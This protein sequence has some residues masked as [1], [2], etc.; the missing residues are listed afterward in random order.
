MT[1]EEIK[2]AIEHF[3]ELTKNSVKKCQKKNYQKKVKFYERMLKN[4]HK[5]Q[6]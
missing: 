5:Q 3:K 6:N 2:T 4:T 1:K